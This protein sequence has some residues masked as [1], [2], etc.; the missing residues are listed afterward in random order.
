MWEQLASGRV[1][2]ST[3]VPELPEVERAV[4]ALRRHIVGRSITSIEV[5]HPSL[6]RRLGDAGRQSL[7]GARI[8]AVRRRGKHQL[9][10]LDDGRVL[11]AHFRM[12]GDWVAGPEAL[13]ALYPR[14]TFRLDDDSIVVLDDPRALSSLTV[15]A[16]GHDP[17][18]GV[19]PEADDPS[20]DAGWLRER[21]ARRTASIKQVLLDQSVMAGIGNIYAAESLWRARINPRRAARRLALPDL[22]RLLAAI[23]AVLKKASG[24]RYSD[25]GGRFEVYDREGKPCRRCRS[26]IRRIVQGARSTYYCPTCQR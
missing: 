13:T 1:P 10:D 22:R 20:I 9:I 17:V 23:R 12:T 5:H 6:A 14:A 7:V 25:G 19:G 21:F 15:H 2:G 24:T 11:Q 4:V 8:T 3:Q 16:A 18:A 26:P